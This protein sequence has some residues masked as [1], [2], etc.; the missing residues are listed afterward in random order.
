MLLA[1]GVAAST[2]GM[3]VTSGLTLLVHAIALPTYLYII[4]KISKK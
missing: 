2:V 1:L 3:F 4:D